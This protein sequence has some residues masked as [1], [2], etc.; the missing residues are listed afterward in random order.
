[1]QTIPLFSDLDAGELAEILSLA[2][3]FS[4]AAGH[5][6]FR[7]G[8]DA[9]GMLVIERGRVR[10]SSRLLGE[11]EVE[12]SILGAGDVLGEYSLVDRGARSATAR[13][14]EPCDGLFFSSRHFEVLRTDLRPAAFKTMR[15]MTRE[16]SERLRSLDRAIGAKSSGATLRRLPPWVRDA[17]DALGTAVSNAVIDRRALRLL[18][19]FGSLE[20]PEVEE[21]LSILPAWQVSKGRI[22]IRQGNPAGSAFVLVRGAV[23]VVLEVEHGVE[24]VAVLGPGK[25]FGVSLIENRPRKATC[26]A[27]EPSIVLEI[28]ARR[29]A[30]LFEG[31]SPIA[32]KLFDALDEMLIG[33]LRASNRRLG[34]LVALER[35]G[36][37]RG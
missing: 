27:R 34:R 22:L 36:A 37:R 13:V 3:P 8:D 6:I 25:I 21:L 17:G 26:Y 32:F 23:Q 19:F 16:L 9:D 7:Q 2:R 30:E 4:F 35:V 5:T 33:Q 11:D 24:D 31:R 20:S 1:L 18:P 15:K 14:I 29:F 28:D 10:V 12:L